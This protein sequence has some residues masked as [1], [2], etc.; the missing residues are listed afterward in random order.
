MIDTNLVIFGRGTLVTM[1]DPQSTDVV[2]RKTAAVTLP[3]PTATAT[4]A[5]SPTPTIA[6]SPTPTSTPRPTPSKFGTPPP[7]ITS[8]PYPIDNGTTIQT[9]PAITRAGV[10][11]FGKIYRDAAQDGPFSAWAFTATSP[12]DNTVGIDTLYGGNIP[13]AA[14]KFVALQLVGNP[15]IST[16]NGGA[17]NLALISVGP[18]TSAP[19]GDTVFTFTG[20]QS[21]LLATQNGPITLNG[22]S[23]QSIPL[24]FFYARGPGSNLTLGSAISNVGALRLMAENNIQINAFQSLQNGPNGGTLLGI[25]GGNFSVNAPINTVTAVVPAPTFAGNRWECFSLRVERCGHRRFAIQGAFL[26]IRETP[27]SGLGF[28]SSA[29]GSISLKERP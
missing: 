4:I 8:V 27:G 19:A 2:D 5:P 12:F 7:I 18:M 14:F 29:G 11:D 25:A 26:P 1:T 6:P 20:M 10:T 15:T 3:T 21:V 17:T 9:D 28:R 16:A 13:V 23:F 24:L 22:I